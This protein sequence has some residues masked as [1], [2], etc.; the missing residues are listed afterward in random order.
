[1]MTNGLVK[2]TEEQKMKT[3]GGAGLMTFFVMLLPSLISTVIE[4]SLA[5]KNAVDGKTGTDGSTG[6]KGF[7]AP[8]PFVRLAAVPKK[9]KMANKIVRSLKKIFTSIDKVTNQVGGSEYAALTVNTLRFLGVDMVAK[10]DSGHPGIVL[11]AAPIMYA[12]F[13]NH[14]RYDVN[15][16]QLFNRDRFVLSAGHGSALLYSTMHLAGYKQATLDELKNFRQAG[17]RT[18][19]HPENFL[20]EG[21]EATTGPLGQGIAQGVG[22]AFAESFLAARYNAA[23]TLISHYT[24]V[25]F[26]D[27]CLQEGVALEAIALAGRFK[28]NRLIMLY[29][30]NDVQLDGKVGDST[31]TDVRKLFEAYQ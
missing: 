29:D 19:G 12:L 8:R 31:N 28:L 3:S 10:A 24:Y 18:A 6:R 15:E 17:A 20:L 13:R 23:G 22:M 1:M 26:G 4:G 5:I 11:G 27:G 16:P 2:L 25:L 7:S 14:L 9:V 30:S 21:V